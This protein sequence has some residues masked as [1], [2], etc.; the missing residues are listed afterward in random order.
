MPYK[1]TDAAW[2]ARE[3]AR[4]RG[5][6]ECNLV[7]GQE[8]TVAEVLQLLADYGIDYTNPEYAEI[9]AQLIADGVI[10]ATT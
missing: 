2:L 3:T 4:A 5:I 6:L 10:E 8:Y 9:G 1:L 7:R